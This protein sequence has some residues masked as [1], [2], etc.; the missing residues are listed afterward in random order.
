MTISAEPFCQGFLESH[1][2]PFKF[3]K[4]TSRDYGY[5]CSVAQPII[6]RASTLKRIRPVQ[7]VTGCK[8]KGKAYKKEKVFCMYVGLMLVDLF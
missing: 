3:L 7:Y 8:R 4:C 2:T 6:L 5:S 1:L